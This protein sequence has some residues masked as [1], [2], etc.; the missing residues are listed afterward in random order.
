MAD[1]HTCPDRDDL[2]RMI[3]NQLPDETARH[4]QVHLESCAK[5]R[6]ALEQC[7]TSDELL[8]TVRAR[9]GISA[10]PTKTIYLPADWLR[11]AVLTWIRAHD[12]TQSEKNALPLSTDDIK[13]LLGPPGAPGEL[14]RV[15]DFSVL[16]V[17]GVG[18][19]AI[20]FEAFDRQ[21]KR[22]VALKLMLPAV[23]SKPGGTGQFLRE[24]QSAA[25][26]KHEHVVTVYQ[27]GMHGT[28]PFI[29][30]EL[31]HGESLEDRLAKGSFGL[32]EVLRIGREIAEGLAAA[33]AQSLLHRDIKP[34]NIWLERPAPLRNDV[35]KSESRTVETTPTTNGKRRFDKVNILDFGCAKVWTDDSGITHFGLLIGTPAYM[36]PEQLTGKP[37]DPRADLFSLGCV[38]YR[39]ASGRPAFGG[40][41]LLAVVRSL[42]LDEPIPLAQLDPKIP[43]SLSDLVDQLLSKKADGRPASAQ[44]IVDQ[45]EE[46]ERWHSKPQRV[47]PPTSAPPPDAPGNNQTRR[48]NRFAAALALTLLLPLAY[49]LFGAQLVRIV[50]N[51]GQIVIEVDEP[52]VGVTVTENEIVIHDGRGQAEITLA[53]GEHQLAVTL[54]QPSGTSSFETENFTLERGGKKILRVR[55]QLARVA[56]TSIAAPAKATTEKSP[57]AAIE[58][59]PSATA[60]ITGS[61]TG[62]VT[63]PTDPDRSA[64]MWTLS[65]R[66]FVFLRTEP[67]APAIKVTDDHALPAGRFE[68][69]SVNLGGRPVTDADLMQFHGLA[70]LIEFALNGA[71]VTN[72]GVA[73]LQD[74]PELKNLAL[75]NTRVTDAGLPVVGKLK[76]LELLFL[77]GTQ[78]TDNGLKQL[79]PLQNL[80]HLDL[81]NT[82]ASD[83]AIVELARLPK[84]AE[85]LLGKTRVTDV[86]LADIRRL[87]Q[88][89]ALNLSRL[90]IG[91]AGLANVRGLPNLQSLFIDRTRV[92][93]A[94]LPPLAD[95]PQLHTLY[96]D[97]TAITNNGLAGLA[98]IKNLKILSLR[99]IGSIDDTA[100]PKLVR[101]Q[102][103][104]RLDI[105]DCHISA[106]GFAALKAAMSN[107]EIAWTEPNDTVAKAVLG[108]KGTIDVLLTASGGQRH[109]NTIAEL[110]D[111]SYQVTAVQM[112]ATRESV[113]PPLVA[114]QKLGLG[115]LVSVDLSNTAANNDDVER[116]SSI[117]TLRE[118]N[119]ARTHI[120]DAALAHLKACRALNRLNID[121]TSIQGSGLF[122]LQALPE[123]RELHLGG[124]KLN[125]LFLGELAGLPKLERLALSNCHLS[126]TA[127]QTLA[128]LTQLRELDLCQTKLT[129]KQ[130]ADLQK[131]LPNCRI[132]AA[133]MAKP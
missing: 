39:M 41:D 104:L 24:A 97:E 32:G 128:R 82:P 113:Y 74:L 107:L 85:L 28:T 127:A 30:M 21:L 100:V 110:P 62:P 116:L 35:S 61:I 13:R 83:A 90:P 50:T 118:V 26:L 120:T 20:V 64:A 121:G 48:R 96:L 123:L 131:T 56:S 58:R 71:P 105:R 109:V 40:D 81:I 94:G 51:K 10:D 27:V 33:H 117:A 67:G 55:R 2:Q 44:A 124:P 36:A 129:P 106:K 45:L 76:K 53:A 119:L 68:L 8:D 126:T 34:A 29:A 92:T 103:L 84:L 78:V 57:G 1:P 112:S 72:A 95:V 7:V 70:H 89:T 75:S 12:S 87:S 114:M 111:E 98:G 122:H 60:P 79:E 19:M 15:A 11:G 22:S 38:L 73:N 80:A 14:G 3:L 130:L 133:S 17:L 88:L 16:R 69:T 91:N 86:G 93:D 4:I 65:K 42:A 37:V 47:E 99:G 9:R 31:L 23:A 46:I 43:Q 63:A 66:G 102:N 115:A 52:S 108:A 6:H 18:G 5:C 77:D 49:Y 125:E 132:I 59:Q 25:A 54:K 101:L